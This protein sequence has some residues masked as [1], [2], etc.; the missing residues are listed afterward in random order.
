MDEIEAQMKEKEDEMIFAPSE[1]TNDL[2]SSKIIDF[3][4]DDN[5]YA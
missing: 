5:F 3:R 2:K 1:D 4:V